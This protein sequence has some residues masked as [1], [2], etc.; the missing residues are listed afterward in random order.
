MP[1]ATR[2][3][4][5]HHAPIGA[6]SSFTF[7]LPGQGVSIDQECTTIEPC[8][9]L[10]VALVHGSCKA[11]VLPFINRGGIEGDFLNE[12][13]RQKA[14]TTA[15]TLRW[16][17]VPETAVQRLLEAA[18]D[19]FATTDIVL[20][21]HTPVA[22][23]PDPASGGDPRAA[24][25]PALLI[26]V[27]FDNRESDHT[28]HGFVGLNYRGRERIRPLDWSATDLCGIAL[29]DRW[30]LAAKPEAGRVFTVRHLHL[31]EAVEAGV[32]I[33]HNSGNQG[34]IL[35][36]VPPRTR[37]TL[38]CVFGFYRPGV[39][40][41]G[42]A[43]KYW[44]TRYYDSVEAVCR[45]ALDGAE[46]IRAEAK[47][48]N[49]AAAR[50][51]PDTRKRELYAQAVRAYLANT[52][53]TI[54]DDDSVL[55]TVVEGRFLWRNTL[56]LAVD[57][58]PFELAHNAW[59]VRNLVDLCLARYSYRDRVDFSGSPGCWRPGGLTFAHDMGSHS[60]YAPAGRSGYE[61]GG[62]HAYAFMT[63][64]ELLNGCYLLTACL[65]HS[66]DDAW[67]RG[68][69][70]VLTELIT[71]LENRD[72]HD[73]AER[74][75]LLKARSE[76]CGEAGIE[77]TTYDAL[78]PAL[79]DTAGNAY[80]AV[81]TWCAAVML[82]AAAEQ[83]G[84]RATAGRAHAFAR[85]T[86]ASLERHFDRERHLFPT[87]LWENTSGAA[88]AVIEPIGVPYFCGL[89]SE[90][91][92]FPALMECLRRH[93]RTCLREGASLD[94]DSGAVRLSSSSRN[95][96]PSKTIL[97]L[98]VAEQILA[99][100]LGP[101]EHRIYDSLLQW[102]QVAAARCT[103]ADQ[104]DTQ[105]GEFVNGYYYPRCVTAFLWLSPTLAHFRSARLHES[106][107]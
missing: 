74:D 49:E 26:D 48:Q 37:A 31:A 8:H 39:A 1:A 78:D 54:A 52:Q 76:R 61:L 62:T 29:M 16:T 98:A 59:M 25:C 19:K 106:H 68:H 87:T 93:A 102:T 55:F 91:E 64:E 22:A 7:G 103:I 90:L 36:R 12:T 73:A 50:L 6:W 67:T 21:V 43:S 18:T 41:Q 34:G 97:C 94:P 66:N 32:P 85:R 5:T 30:A 58:L 81:K 104:I 9:D 42:L 92:K 63:T 70:S 56:D 20:T 101:R 51:C 44:F 15:F 60:A 83:A 82:A 45:G 75:G 57:H 79:K 33:V 105:T 35:I 17:I 99:V 100:D 14:Q 11:R 53:L 24:L 72:H 71:S 77:I 40:T 88:A 65:L 80:I 89:A 4:Q 46:K 86:A 28:A 84:E 23:V 107:A 27:V 96:W 3:F 10:I 2:F 38:P 47:R 13:E 69:R 95:G